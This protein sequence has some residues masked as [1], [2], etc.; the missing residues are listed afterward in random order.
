[1]A[2]K[3]EAIKLYVFDLDGTLMDSGDTIY[4]AMHQ[5]FKVLGFDYFIPREWLDKRIGGHF[6][7]IFNEFG[8][9][10]PD[11]EEYINAY[12]P[13]YFSYIDDTRVYPG[14]PET[15]RTLK[16]QNKKIAMLTTKAQEQAEKISV[17][18][19]LDS[20]F[21]VIVGRTPGTPVKPAPEPLIDICTKLGVTACESV[22][23]GDTEY[24]IRCGKNAG[25]KTCAVEYG[26]RS[27]E[28]LRAEKPDY[29]IKTMPDLLSIR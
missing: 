15:L 1:M 12:K 19:N 18:F 6:Q 2:E 22:M 13:L 23:V 11:I 28:F 16:E 20:F 26:Y 9:V 3:N 17:Y 10:I 24:D 25:V 14:V 29:I 4:Q 27:T 21:E 8:I 7:D 5:T